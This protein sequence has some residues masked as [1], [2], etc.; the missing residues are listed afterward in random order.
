MPRGTLAGRLAA[1]GFADTARAGR[2]LTDDLRL[3]TGGAD[4][5]LVQAIAGAA[6]PDLALTALARIPPEAGLGP[7]LR[8][9]P[10]LRDRLIAVLGASAALGAHLAR[11]PGQW[12]VL[13]GPGALAQPTAAQLKTELLA[14]VG[15]A[16]P[17]PVAAL[18]VAY[19]RRLL[20]LAARDLTG[21][22]TIEQTAAELAD[23]AAAALEAALAIAGARLGPDRARPGS[24]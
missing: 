3:D 24:R 14:A 17:D 16:A 11:H 20:H 5:E 4:A 12:R 19:R 8:A 21:V 13:A 6:D 18:R 1:L 23:L 10:G 2:L 7:A 9:D 22:V 15:A